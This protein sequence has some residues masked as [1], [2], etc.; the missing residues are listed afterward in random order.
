MSTNGKK[1]VIT[2]EEMTKV[3]KLGEHEVRALNGVSLTIYE[4]EFVA[5]MGP[6]GS[7]KSTMMNMLG[8]LDKPTSGRYILGGEDV[9]QLNDDALADIRNRKIGFVFQNFNLLSRTPAIEQVELPLV[10][11]GKSQR[12]QKAQAA[13]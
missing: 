7:G 9:S 10:Y 3:Y 12:R 5:I 6:S 11:A 1:P 2:I 4:G 8:A 13:L